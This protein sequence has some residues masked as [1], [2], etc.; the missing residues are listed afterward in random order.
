ME[1]PTHANGRRCVGMTAPTLSVSRAEPA[2]LDYV[3]ALLE[4]NDLPCED[5]R[6]K[7]ASLFVATVDDE[8]V[9]VGGFESYGPHGLLRSVVV[10][11]SDRGQGFG[12]AQYEALESEARADGVRTLYL[13]TTTAAGFFADLGYRVIGRSSAPA[14][15]QQTHEFADACPASATCMRKSL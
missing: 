8:S 4:A 5:V 3:E 7:P 9:G 14:A 2:D 10:E 15:I 6:A 1:A 12:T 11:R 13:L